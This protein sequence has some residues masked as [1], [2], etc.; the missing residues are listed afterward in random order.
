[1]YIYDAPCEDGMKFHLAR[2]N[3][4]WMMDYVC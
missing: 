1:M 4:K 2:L 3:Y